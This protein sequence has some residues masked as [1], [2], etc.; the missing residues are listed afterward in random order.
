MCDLIKDIILRGD[1]SPLE[2]DNP[3]KVLVG[4]RSYGLTEQEAFNLI[5]KENDL[6]AD[7][8]KSQ[9]AAL[10]PELL[11]LFGAQHVEDA[12]DYAFYYMDKFKLDWS[13]YKEILLILLTVYKPEELISNPEL[14]RFFISN[15]DIKKDP[16][17][18]KKAKELSVKDIK[19]M[20]A[21]P[22]DYDDIEEEEDE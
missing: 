1:T 13:K 21:N 15:I 17:A 2:I 11:E 22:H 6:L 7:Y 8:E 12:L 3:R 5:F 10:S 19:I 18:L 20:C 16:E 14:I 9:Q 4:L